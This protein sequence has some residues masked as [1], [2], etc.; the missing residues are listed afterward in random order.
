[1]R[2]KKKDQNDRQYFAEWL[3]RTLRNRGISNGSLSRVLDVSPSA[4][5]RWTQGGSISLSNVEGLAHYL[6]VDFMRLAVT[7]EIVG[8]EH[9]DVLPMPDNTAQRDY[10]MEQLMKIKDITDEQRQILMRAYDSDQ[11]RRSG[12]NSPR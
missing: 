6:G 10:V 2:T 7:A 9:S 8:P 12:E 5:T 1:M 11:D 4:V 3:R